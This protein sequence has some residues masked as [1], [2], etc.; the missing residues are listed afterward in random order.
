MS[1]PRVRVAPTQVLLDTV[2]LQARHWIVLGL[3][4][5]L[6][7]A[8]WW[9]SSGPITEALSRW[10]FPTARDDP[11]HAFALALA[12][13]TRQADVF[14]V[15]TSVVL[16]NV[17]PDSALSRATGLDVVNLGTAGQS[18]LECLYILRTA[19]LHRGQLVVVMVTP[20]EMAQGRGGVSRL[21]AGLWPGDITGFAEAFRDDIPRL[22]SW[23][24]S[25]AR[26]R[27]AFAVQR[28]LLYRETHDAV[29]QW[30]AVHLY[31]DQRPVW[32]QFRNDHRPV[33]NLRVQQGHRELLQRYL[34]T[35]FETNRGDNIHMLNVL[36][37]FIHA[38]GAHAV[39]LAPPRIA[40]DS[41][42]TYGT[43]WTIFQ[44]DMGALADSNALPYVDRNDELA[45]RHTEF[46]DP[47]HVAPQGRVRW[48]R[49]LVE[50]ISQ[51]WCPALGRPADGGCR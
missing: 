43:A 12:P 49:V 2:P 14:L 16:E 6:G 18:L 41:L 31:G 35:G 9:R 13:A 1:A 21:I 38:Q 44:A 25:L 48:S 3:L 45:F 17:L 30:A 37:R 11:G 27:I 15:G 10:P 5:A 20:N 26:R 24:T 23:L 36:F 34:T 28:R 22:E 29:G 46:F 33:G 51:Q 47:V 39:L 32:Q 8:A 19:G 50:L 7:L 42:R 40:D 4:V